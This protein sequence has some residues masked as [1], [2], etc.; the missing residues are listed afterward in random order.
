MRPKQQETFTDK[1]W[2]LRRERKYWR[3]KM[4]P[5]KTLAKEELSK[6]WSGHIESDLLLSRKEHKKRL[7]Q[8][9]LE[10][11]L[12]YKEGVERRD[13]FLVEHAKQAGISGE[14]EVEKAV[15][16]IRN[17]EKRNREFRFL[18]KVLKLWFRRWMYL[19]M[20]SQ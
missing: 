17:Q 11:M 10:V 8:A 6:I 19:K 16:E 9:Q 3:T 13:A 1:L 18:R 20:L 7:V 2:E 12:Q 5:Q 14:K 15:N 4:F